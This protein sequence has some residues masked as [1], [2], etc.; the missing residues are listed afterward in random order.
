MCPLEAW[1]RRASV[2]L[3]AFVYAGGVATPKVARALLA[4][5]LGAARRR[6]GAPLSCRWR[7]PA[8]QPDNYDGPNDPST[9]GQVL[10][11]P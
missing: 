5:K 10:L 1:C 3:R 9:D 8:V 6:L 2:H 4:A 11:A 7:R